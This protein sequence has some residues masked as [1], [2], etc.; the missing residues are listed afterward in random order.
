MKKETDACTYLANRCC[1]CDQ[2]LGRTQDLHRH[3]KLH[4]HENWTHMQP[5]GIQLT[6]LYGEDPPCPYCNALFK[7]NHQCQVWT[8]LAMLLMYGGG[9]AADATPV[10]VTMRREICLDTF[11]SHDDLHEH[12]V[13]VHRLS[14]GSYKNPARDTLDGEPVRNHCHAMYDNTASLRSHIN[15]GRGPKFNQ[16]M[17]TEVVDILSQWKA[18]ICKGLFA[19]TLR[20][21]HVRLQLTLRGQNCSCHCTRGANLSG[22]LQAAHAQLWSDSQMLTRIMVSLIYNE[23]GCI[24]NPGVSAPRVNHICL[25]LRQLAMQHMRMT[26]DIL[27]PH[28]PTEEELAALF[29]QTLDRTQRFMLQRALTERTLHDFWTAEAHQMMLRQTCVLCGTTMHP[30]D[31]VS[32]LYEAHQCGQPI[33]QFLIQQLVS[34]FVECNANDYQRSACM[35]TYNCPADSNTHDDA[36]LISTQAHFRAQCPCLLQTAIILGKSAHG[37]HGY[38]R[39]R[40]NVQPG[41]GGFSGHHSDAGQDVDPGAQLSG[42]QASKKRRTSQSSA[43]PLQAPAEGHGQLGSR[44][45]ADGKISHTARQGSTAA[46]KGGHLHLLFRAQ[47]PKQQRCRLRKTGSRTTSHHPRKSM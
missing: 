30:A 6:N 15:Q 27:F 44:R 12:L 23:A 35:Q 29:S 8:Q 43:R 11:P 46:E 33:V 37:R 26:G 5:K 39:H 10:P 21:P 40:R 4:H 25:P 47:R 7:S 2:F 31:L 32:N 9:L 17:R 36:R 34:K 18:A 41:S 1:L 14:S 28:N 20:D 3:Y 16:D 45:A 13:N 22:H 38:A 24:C 19:D 42:T